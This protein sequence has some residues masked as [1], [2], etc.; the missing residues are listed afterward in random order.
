MLHIGRRRRR[1]NSY[2]L[3]PSEHRPRILARLL[4]GGVLLGILWF[5]GK[6]VL[7]MFGGSSEERSAVMIA[8]EGRGDV[9]VSLQGEDALR[10]ES[11]LALY[12]GDTT[13]TRVGSFAVV[14]FFDGTLLRLDEETE[15]TIEESRYRPE[16][17]SSI[18]VTLS[19]GQAWIMTP[20]TETFSGSV[21]RTLETGTL[22]A[23]VQGGSEGFIGQNEVFFL[24]TAGPGA[25]IV[26]PFAGGTSLLVGEGQ[27]FALSETAKRDIEAGADPYLFRDPV[28]ADLTASAFVREST[29][30][31]AAVM[32]RTATSLPSTGT[33]AETG[34]LLTISSPSNNTIV[35]GDTVLIGGSAHPR[36]ETVNVNGYSI[37]V[38]DDGTFSQEL[39]LPNSDTV[40]IEFEGRDAS[41]L[42]IAQA[43]RTIQRNR[44]PPPP[45][46]ITAPGGSGDTITVTQGEVDITGTAPAGTNGIVVN[47]YRL[48][49]F[50]P[51]GRS[52]SYIASTSL[53]NLTIGENV[54]RIYA[55]DE[56]GARSA[57]AVI[58]IVYQPEGSSATGGVTPPPETGLQNNSPLEPGSVYM[59]LPGRGE[60]FETSEEEILLEGN[61]SAATATVSVNGYQLQLYEAGNTFWNYIAST[62]LGTMRPGTNVYRIVARN[63][64]GQVLDI[65]EYTITYRP[66]S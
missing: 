8:A 23:S 7:S 38:G 43:S 44:E 32:N 46:A 30:S 33:G 66:A 27:H 39:T 13:F 64:E 51:G 36:V 63:A 28:S 12:P 5:T 15:L 35:T 11:G 60:S 24:R 18:A 17:T 54:F 10:A 37:P 50:Q 6:S 34:D 3:A 53:G 1:R 40:L 4:V 56:S 29:V 47:D 52:W 55:L 2:A 20:D 22:I 49:L 19:K 21:T 31:I 48:Q 9:D 45:P 16:G 41:G 65:L 26:L 61:T 14:S 57:P 58:T 62:D 59:K 42:V 25:E